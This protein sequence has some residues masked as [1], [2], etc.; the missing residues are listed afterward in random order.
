M[1]YTITYWINYKKEIST[2]FKTAKKYKLDISSFRTLVNNK[3]NNE[4]EILDNL[5]LPFKIKIKKEKPTSVKL[6]YWTPAIIST[7][8]LLKKIIITDHSDQASKQDK[9]IEE[10][11]R[12]SSII[13]KGFEEFHLNVLKEVF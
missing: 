11:L 1:I 7:I 2:K 5:N 6:P 8:K 12:K 13:T 9:I 10:L 4:E 3:R